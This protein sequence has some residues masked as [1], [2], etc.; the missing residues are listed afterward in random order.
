LGPESTWSAEASE[1]AADQDAFWEYH[2]YLFGN[3]GGENQVAFSKEN[4]KKFAAELDLD[5]QAFDEC[6]DSGKYTQRV[7]TQ[8]GLAQQIGV[9]S[10]P[11]F[12]VNGRPVVGAQPFDVFQQLITEQLGSGDS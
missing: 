5:T 3:H 10:T 6:L 7:Q 4:L 12:I 9:T 11:S 8:T 1:C 2:D